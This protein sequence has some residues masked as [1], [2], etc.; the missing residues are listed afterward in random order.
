VILLIMGTMQNLHQQA[1]SNG[2]R[3]Q[4][5]KNSRAIDFPAN[6]PGIT[7]H[8]KFRNIASLLPWKFVTWLILT[9]NF[10]LKDTIT[11]ASF[12]SLIPA[13]V[14][15]VTLGSRDVRIPEAITGSCHVGIQK[16]KVDRPWW[17]TRKLT[18][19]SH[20]LTT[21]QSKAASKKWAITRALLPRGNKQAT[22]RKAPIP[23][24]PPFWPNK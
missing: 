21:R 15:H 13:S 17:L 23:G 12:V 9:M 3:P 6:K 19:H 16:P 11:D 22:Q 5:Q 2:K 14:T 10:L 24:N 4:L 8:S 7:A 1:Q 18:A 20:P